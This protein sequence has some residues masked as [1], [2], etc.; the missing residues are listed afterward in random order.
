M[1]DLF[2]TPPRGMVRIPDHSTSEKAAKKVKRQ[3]I[4]DLVLEVGERIDSGFIDEEVDRKCREIERARDPEHKERAE[5]SYR[6]RRTELSD[7]GFFLDTGVTRLNSKGQD[8]KV[9]IHRK[10]HPAPPPITVKVKGQRAQAMQRRKENALMFNALVEAARHFTDSPHSET[11]K[12][13]AEA[14]RIPFPITYS[15]I[16]AKRPI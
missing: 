1:P 12:A 16:P 3:T 13:I 7:E 8:S 15:N 9:W 5:S 11:G 6:K 10:F 4:R 2:D 14:L